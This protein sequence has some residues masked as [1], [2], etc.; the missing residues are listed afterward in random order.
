MLEDLENRRMFAVTAAAFHDTLYVW[1]DSASN[2][3]SV[4]KSGADLVVKQYVSG[5]GYGE[6]FRASDAYVQSIRVY[7]YDGADTISIADSV[8]DPATVMGGRGG[9]YLKGGGGQT[10][11]WGHGNW[12]G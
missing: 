11:L 3:I 7:G 9:D 1:G 6:I 5:S 2:G 4:E 8:T 12:A 10:E